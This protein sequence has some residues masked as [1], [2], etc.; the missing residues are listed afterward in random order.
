MRPNLKY[1][2]LDLYERMV[3][4]RQFWSILDTWEF[5]KLRSQGLEPC[6]D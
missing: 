2:A 1:K 6:R 3:T 5:I 4:L